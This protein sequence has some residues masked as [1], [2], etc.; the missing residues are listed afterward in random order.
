M[1]FVLAFLM[2]VVLS[3]PAAAWSPPSK[4]GGPVKSSRAPGGWTWCVTA[5]CG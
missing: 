2:I 1:K 5:K 3:G 4:Q